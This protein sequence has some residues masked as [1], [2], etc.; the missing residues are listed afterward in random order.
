MIDAGFP[1]E[2]DETNRENMVFYFPIEAPKGA[3][4]RDDTTAVQ[5]LEHWKLYQD[6]WC[7]H[8]PSV[9][10]TVRE[11]EWPEVGAWVW[12]NFDDM[13]GVSFLPHTD[14]SYR[15]APYQ[16][17]DLVQFLQLQDRM[18][19]E[20]DWSNLAQYEN[21]DEFVTATKELACTGG[22]CDI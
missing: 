7:E 16:E 15:Q 21:N 19:K 13:S 5:D 8:K 4:T 2:Q 11:N 6:H 18:P 10:I 9:T 17:L 3:I 12:N 22:V 1:H 14:H 20:V